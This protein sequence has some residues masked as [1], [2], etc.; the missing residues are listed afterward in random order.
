MYK[1]LYHF[2]QNLG[3]NALSYEVRAKILGKN[4]SL[5]IPKRIF[6]TIDDVVI[7]ETNM[8]FE[9]VENGKLK[10]CFGL[11]NFVNISLPNLP[12]IVVFD[13]HNHALFFWCEAMNLGIL[14]PN[15]ELIHIDEHSDLWANDNI[16]DPNEIINLE[17]AWNFTNF[18]CN[19]GNYIVPAIHAGIV[20]KMI[21][22]ENEFQLD[23]NLN[24]TPSK[25][26]VLNLDLD[27]F[28][29]DLDHINENKKIACVKNLLKKVKYV[30]I[31]TSPYFIE[32]GH[33][34]SILRRII[35]EI[36]TE[37]N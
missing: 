32:Q 25:N 26:S 11:E 20:E 7:S 22:I 9:E 1:N 15:F 29:P 21:R 24:Y 8:V 17:Y 13:N 23:E 16:F 37:Q 3:N 4:P 31:C 35:A 10:S 28:S 19:V 14:E 33:A 34:L 30:T 27:F 2:T 18:S 36:T 5:I 6:G 12:E